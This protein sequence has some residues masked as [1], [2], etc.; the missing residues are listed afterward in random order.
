[1]RTGAVRLEDLYHYIPVAPQLARGRVTGSAIKNSIENMI[2][3]AVNSDVF[4]WTG[5]WFFGFSGLTMDVNPYAAK[6]SRASNIMVYRR[7]SGLWEPLNTAASYVV[8]GYWYA[9]EPTTVA[10]YKN[11]ANVEVFY[12]D[13]GEVMDATTVLV[14][15]LKT[16]V[17]DPDMNRIHLTAP[18]PAPVVRQSGDAAAQGRAGRAVRFQYRPGSLDPGLS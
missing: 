8:S 13:N 1:M 14:N 11:A 6:G 9:A 10:G 4:A 3:G 5:G 18:L 2:D 16:K 17:A 15:Y 12:G 7:D